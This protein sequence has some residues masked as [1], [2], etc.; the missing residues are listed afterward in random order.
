MR[1]RIKR[2]RHSCKVC[3]PGKTGQSNRWSPREH[4]LLRRFEKAL[5]RGADWNDA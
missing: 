2:K 1:K 3:K 4:M 5:Q